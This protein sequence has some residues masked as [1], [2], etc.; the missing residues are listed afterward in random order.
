ML[1]LRGGETQPRKLGSFQFILQAEDVLKETSW[2][3]H[4]IPGRGSAGSSMTQRASEAE[5][6][7]ARCDETS[8]IDGIE[9][10]Q[11]E[12][13]NL[14]FIRSSYWTMN[15]SEKRVD[16]RVDEFRRAIEW[17]SICI[18]SCLRLENPGIQITDQGIQF[19]VLLYLHQPREAFTGRIRQ[20]RQQTQL[21]WSVQYSEYRRMC[22]PWRLLELPEPR[23]SH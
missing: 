18:S 8:L 12:P 9:G 13:A 10:Q 14:I 23:P 17:R 20:S 15:C 7:S 16:N 21:L 5:G 11:R 1:Y 6:Q 22:H 3:S 19:T 4:P 2:T